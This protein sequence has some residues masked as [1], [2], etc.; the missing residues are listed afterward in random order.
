[1]SRSATPI[2]I[3]N[4]ASRA[5]RALFASTVG[6]TIDPF[7]RIIGLRHKEPL[8]PTFVIK[9]RCIRLIP[10]YNDNYDPFKPAR[11]NLK[12]NYSPYSFREPLFNDRPV[13]ASNLPRGFILAPTAN[14]LI[15]SWL[16]KVRYILIQPERN[17][18][19]TFWACKLCHHCPEFTKNKSNIF[20]SNSLKNAKAHMIG[21][22]KL[23]ENGDIGK[24]PSHAV[25]PAQPSGP[26]GGDYENIIPFRQLEFRNAFTKWVVM[27]DVKY[28]KAVS[29]YLRRLFKIANLR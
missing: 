10:L 9:D 22:Y 25:P 21:E 7:T 18:K 5:S 16:W 4:V 27:D 3:D 26:V 24:L 6:A 8:P 23:D 15:R 14:I 2:N 20:N 1:M 28:R 12:L 11:D 13:K 29:L 17:K 19:H